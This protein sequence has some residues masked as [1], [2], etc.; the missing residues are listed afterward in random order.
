M[1]ESRTA[2]LNAFERVKVKQLGYCNAFIRTCIN[3][4]FVERIELVSY[5]TPVVAI[6]F[7]RDGKV[8][9]IECSPAAVCTATTRKHVGRFLNE[10]YPALTYSDI[11]DALQT[12]P[13]QQFGNGLRCIVMP[14][15]YVYGLHDVHR[16]FD[17]R[18]ESVKPFMAWY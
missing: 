10:Y 15:R 2:T 13:P 7:N 16:L 3:N 6:E 1:L 5:C 17:V 11:K 14:G 12:V 8:H 18:Y 9:C 4:K